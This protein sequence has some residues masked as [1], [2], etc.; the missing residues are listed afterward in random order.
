MKS[1]SLN[2]LS[3]ESRQEFGA[4]LLLD[5]LM[6]F[7][8]LRQEKDD[9]YETV[10]KL[11]EEVAELKKGFFHSDEQDQELNYEKDELGEAQDALA[12][13]EKEMGENENFLLFFCKK[14]K[15]NVEKKMKM[16]TKISFFFQKKSFFFIFH[17]FFKNFHF[18]SFS[19][20]H[21]FSFPKIPNKN[22]GQ[23][24]GHDE[25]G[26]GAHSGLLTNLKVWTELTSRLQ[27]L[28]A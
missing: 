5:Q 21:F 19:D 18:F 23:D 25:A 8:M 27:N 16:L 28:I 3:S 24:Q 20:F 9:L 13:V 14:K 6:R 4:L 1:S 7:E 12:Q 10:A 26:N 2:L 15:K 17:F 11:E 22:I